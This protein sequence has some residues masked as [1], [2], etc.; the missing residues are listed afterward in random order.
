MSNEIKKVLIME[1]EI[2]M[3]DAVANKFEASGFKVFKAS[4]GVE[5]LAIAVKEQPDIILLD[6]LMPK[7]NGLAVLKKIRAEQKWGKE[8]DIIMLTNL[9]DSES[10]SEAATYGVFDFLVKTDWKLDDVVKLAKSKLGIS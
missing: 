3:L 4:D 5:G 10:V 8:V 9:S 7:L 6:I 2:A 1:D